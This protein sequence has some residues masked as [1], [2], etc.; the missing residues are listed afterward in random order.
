MSEQA[1]IQTVQQIYADFGQGKVQAI[2]DRINPSV[3]WVNA[4]PEVI[5]YARRRT[6]VEGVR[7]FFETLAT[8]VE[9]QSFEPRE[10]FAAGNRVIAL[11]AW[12]GCARSAKA[13]APRGRS[14]ARRRGVRPSCGCGR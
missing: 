11:G 6:S 10:F 13:A 2:L 9:V 4:G 5:P 1:N 14:P 8:A 7:F 12:S 3:D